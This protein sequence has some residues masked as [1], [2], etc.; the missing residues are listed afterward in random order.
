MCKKLL[1]LF[2]FLIGLQVQAQINFEKGYFI[3]NLGKRTDCLIRNSG[4]KEN[5]DSFE[6]RLTR[7]ASTQTGS[8]AMVKEFGIEG[9]AKYERHTILVDKSSN[10]V[11]YL[12]RE[13]APSFV[14]ERVF[15]EVRV[16][17]KVN[18]YRYQNKRITRFFYSKA[19][20]ES[21]PTQL[22]YKKYK[23]ADN[24]IAENNDFRRQ[25]WTVLA[26]DKMELE[27]IRKTDYRKRELESL[28]VAY[29]ECMNTESVVYN[30]K[31]PSGEWFNLTLKSG[32]RFAS[33]T[34]DFIDGTMRDVDFGDK[35]ALQFG[36]E[37]EFI[38]PFGRN[39][40]GLFTE[41][42]Y[43]SFPDTELQTE[44]QRIVADY[45]S[46]ELYLGIRHYMF[47]SDKVKLFI[48][49]GMLADYPISSSLDYEESDDFKMS[50]TVS[51]F[52]GLGVN[53]LGKV[54]LE[55]RYMSDRDI[56]KNL[57][58]IGN[59]YKAYAIVLGYTIL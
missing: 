22:V 25:L 5:P 3:D 49:G 15:L 4:W 41:F 55:L 11:R 46:V 1:L 23:T 8:L 56:N 26:C 17:G 20:D 54:N 52:V 58:A 44:R 40:W 2:L 47:L 42:A 24:M 30:K 12:S 32:V 29:N 39:K 27:K 34:A 43:Q 7:D 14:E 36:L 16:Q 31:T 13:E 21:A 10:D 37:A 18:L 59:D 50:S 45:Q 53:V 9:E 48:N 51:T 57:V 19:G 6:Y 33:L 35:T 38:L 28:V